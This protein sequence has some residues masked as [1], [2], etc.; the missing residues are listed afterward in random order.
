MSK[1]IPTNKALYA[2]VKAEAKKKFDRWPSAY[3]SAWLVREYKKRGGGYRKAEQGME[4]P[5]EY[6]YGGIT[7]GDSAYMYGGEDTDME[8]YAKGGGIPQR[9]KNKGFTKVGAK[10]KSTRPGKKW[11]VLAKKGDKYKI[12]HGGD[13]NM[14]DF[15][16]HGSNKRKKRFWDRMGGRNSAKAKDPFSPLYWHKRFGTW[17]EGGEIFNEDSMDFYQEGREVQ[18]F[19]E[20]MSDFA[21]N[22]G[23]FFSDSGDTEFMDKLRAAY[24]ATS[25]Q[26]GEKDTPEEK[27]ENNPWSEFANQNTYER[28]K[29]EFR[30]YRKDLESW[31]ASEKE[32]SKPE[33]PT[34]FVFQKGGTNNPGFRALPPEVQQNILDNMGIGGECYACGG[35]KKYQFAGQTF[36]DPFT[37]EE[38]MAMQMP[39]GMLDKV[40]VTAQGSPQEFPGLRIKPIPRFDVESPELSLVPVTGPEQPVEEESSY[41]SKMLNAL[42][43]IAGVQQ[44]NRF[45]ESANAQRQ[46][47]QMRQNYLTDNFVPMMTGNNRGDYDINT[48]IFRPDDYV[49]TQFKSQMAA[50]G[51]TGMVD[52]ETLKAL[53]AAGADIE[54]L[55]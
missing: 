14:K 42:G 8:E 20:G 53:I 5:D 30:K 27:R 51:Q 23:A 7:Y 25:T 34:W 37:E 10:K 35:Q 11:M 49:F 50:G 17:E 18:P 55:D 12:V 54:L 6:M 46:Q 32:G 24:Y 15:K 4:V 13:S 52:E 39:S 28:K 33:S 9:Y 3:G 19:V 31:E 45:M 44:L 43:R 36:D 2:R 16:Q 1:N 40:T 47:S 29:K 26:L 41:D 48:G 21:D 22:I 38:R